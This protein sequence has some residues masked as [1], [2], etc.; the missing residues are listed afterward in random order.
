MIRDHITASFHIEKDDFDLAPF[1]AKGGL[2][3][4]QLLEMRC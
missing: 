1:D 3:K 2:E 4:C